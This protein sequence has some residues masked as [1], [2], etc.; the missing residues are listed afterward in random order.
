VVSPEAVS[1]FIFPDTESAIRSP[2]AD[3]KRKSANSPSAR[4]SA[5]ADEA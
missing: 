2:L 3:E 1:A 4:T 5:E